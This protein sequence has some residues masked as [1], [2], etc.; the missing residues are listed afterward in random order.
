MIVGNG[1]IANAFSN[2]EFP[3]DVIVFASGAS[4]SK[5]SNESA[6]E[7]E[8]E[9]LREVLNRNQDKL[10]IYFSTASVLDESLQNSPYCI[11]KRKM[12]AY[13]VENA[14]KYLIARVS[15]VVG[16][17]GNPKTIFNYF[18]HHLLTGQKFELWE[19]AE[20]NLVDVDDLAMIIIGLLKT[21]RV[22]EIITVV[23]PVSVSV[24]RLVKLLE[25]ELNTKG[26]YSLV[27]KGNKLNFP[28]QLSTGD[29]ME[30]GVNFD[31]DY[32][33]HIVEKYTRHQK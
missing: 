24:L 27:S 16:N 20:R 22:N 1:L 29:L 18:K 11:H 32:Y 10:M 6:F 28:E 33:R 14:S 21:G 2:K 8:H 17:S 9:L 3:M 4:D 19:T 7:R 12:E 26:N 15:N 30:F 23:N 5:N 31:Q 13:L 25:E